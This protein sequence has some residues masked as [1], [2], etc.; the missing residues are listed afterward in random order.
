VFK[1]PSIKLWIFYAASLLFIL[2][3]AYFVAARNT[4][5]INVMPF[6]FAIVLLAIF[7]LKH[8]IYLIIFCTPLSLPLRELVHGLS[9]D[10]FLPTEPLLFGVLL[11]FLLK[12]ASEK[13]FDKK[14]LLHPVS[15]AIYINLAWIFITSMT[16]TMPVVSFKFLLA[17]IWFLIGLYFLAAKLFEGGHNIEKFVWLYII[18]FIIVIFYATYRHIGYGLW[19]KEAAHIVVSPFYND[20]TSYGALLA[21]YLPFLFGFSFYKG[22]SKVFRICSRIAL[23]ILF[24]ALI[25][26]YSRAAWISIFG[27]FLIWIVIKLRIK[28]RT[29]FVTLI[30]AAVFIFVFQT[31]ILMYLEHNSDES[32]ANL[33]QHF[34]SASNISSDAS[35]L[36][37]INRW[38]C[39]IRMFE[40]KPFFGYGPGTYMFQYAPYQLTKDRTIISTNAGD[41][42]NAHSE[43]LGPLAESG[44]MGMLT[45]LLILGVVIY[46]AVKTYSRTNDHRLRMIILASL[47]GLITYYFHGTMN[48]FLD[49]D[50]ASVPFWGFTAIVVALDLYTQKEAGNKKSGEAS[51]DASIQ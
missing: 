18:P 46:T 29:L 19:D 51:P 17:R 3:N 1:N 21:M 6:A 40:T 5:A 16:S 22:G 10:M 25:L 33:L 44:F 43:Y 11:I 2:V 48:N 34:S 12:I 30:S 32:S 4:L 41:A 39:A 9:F 15:I 42:G 38:S 7:S 23:A 28:F 47:I 26:S 45:F 36:E 20:H 13:T 50:K 31:Q 35:N 14:I 8:L 37:R 24:G 27:A 49:T